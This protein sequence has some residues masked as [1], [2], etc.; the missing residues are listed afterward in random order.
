[1]KIEQASSEVNHFNKALAG[2]QP[3]RFAL[4]FI[5]C[6]TNEIRLLPTKFPALPFAERCP[7]EG[8]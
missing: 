3:L 8:T 1:M 4:E 7:E 2:A 6:D 5:L